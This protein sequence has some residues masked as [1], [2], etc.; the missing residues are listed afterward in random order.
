M[1][2][3]NVR[4][5]RA[6]RANQD[7]ALTESTNEQVLHGRKTKENQHLQR[8]H[9][10]A[11]RATASGATPTILQSS[12]TLRL[13]QNHFFRQ[14]KTKTDTRTRVTHLHPNEADLYWTR[15]ERRYPARHR[16][17]HYPGKGFL[18]LSHVVSLC[19]GK[20]ARACRKTIMRQRQHMPHAFKYT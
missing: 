18:H 6:T 12:A 7:A 17:Y 9:I 4:D 1:C 13:S 10:Q 14:A 8:Y 11:Q 19:K 15:A 16:S 20:R 2:H 5:N 3:A